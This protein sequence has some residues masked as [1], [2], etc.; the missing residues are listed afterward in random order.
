MQH[1]V[2]SCHAKSKHPSRFLQG[3]S[4]LILQL[5]GV[6]LE[7]G[8]MCRDAPQ[9]RSLEKDW[10]TSKAKPG[11]AP[12]PSSKEWASYRSL[13]Q[14][15]QAR[16]AGAGEQAQ[17]QPHDRQRHGSRNNPEWMT[18]G[19]G[20]GVEDASGLSVAA[21]RARDFEA[22]RQRMKEEWNRE[23]EQARG[24]A[25]QPVCTCLY[26]KPVVYFLVCLESGR[27]AEGQAP[28]HGLIVPLPYKAVRFQNGSMGFLLQATRLI[29]CRCCWFTGCAQ[30]TSKQACCLSKPEYVQLVKLFGAAGIDVCIYD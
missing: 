27:W 8:V 9:P 24:S 12:G 18:E 6:I 10:R 4:V 17:R 26:R 16:P 28:M 21:R 14:D 5:V 3:Q 22:E 13:P 30:C 23:Q 1:S 7:P 20:A 11:S 2:S 19:A 29:A 15:S 25:N